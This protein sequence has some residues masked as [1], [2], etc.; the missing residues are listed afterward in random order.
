MRALRA[1]PCAG[2]TLDRLIQP[3]ILIVLTA[4]PRHGYRVAQQISRRL[5]GGGQQP[6]LSGIYRF[7]KSMEKKGLVESSWDL[8]RGGPARRTYAITADGQRCLAQWIA[9]LQRYRDGI[10]DLLRIARS[11]VG[12]GRKE[13]GVRSKE[14]GERS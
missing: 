12:K 9:T 4:G 8:S 13:K 10:N 6:D 1:C 11:A 14:I 3:A 2:D 7:L 5:A